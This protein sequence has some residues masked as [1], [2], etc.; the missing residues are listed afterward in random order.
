M[1]SIKPNLSKILRYQYGLVVSSVLQNVMG[2]HVGYLVIRPEF[3]VN[4]LCTI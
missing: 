2:K 1:C 4:T 3:P